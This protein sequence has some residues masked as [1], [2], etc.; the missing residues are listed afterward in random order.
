MV[1]L[2]RILPAA[3]LL[4]SAGLSACS[5]PAG[6]EDVDAQAIAN[7][8]TN[9]SSEVFENN[10]AF[11]SMQSLAVAFPPFAGSA[12]NAATL[13]LGVL[14]RLPQVKG[15]PRFAMR[16]FAGLRVPGEILAI[17]PSNLLGKTFEWDVAT[18]EYVVGNLTGAPANG[19][20]IRLYLVDPNTGFPF[21]PV[22]TIGNVD[23]T[24]ES[25]P[26]G[27]QLGVT[28]RL[29]TVV[30]ADYDIRATQTTLASNL[31]GIGF[32]RSAD[33][34]RQANFDLSL[35][36]R[37]AGTQ[38]LDYTVTGD[39]GTFLVL[40]ADGDQTTADLSF[41]VGRG[42]NSIT[43]EATENA[44]TISG[45][46]LFNGFQVATISGDSG[47]PVFSGA[48]GHELSQGELAAIGEIFGVSLLFLLVLT[49][50]VFGPALV[51]FGL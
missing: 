44:G 43:L 17:F 24:D 3:A 16:P 35:T 20:R 22:Q 31:T 8:L 28:V 50:G 32:F 40:L 25:D 30:V 39:D 14:Q 45:G 2:K 29:F 47:N 42:D 38:G 36:E 5:D 18:D 12:I 49:Y 6:P 27:D 7:G 26:S 11:T 23:L 1:I 51:I 9:L 46:I 10:A 21:E 37:V 34:T 15:T 19:I 33:A 41:E 13:P 4:L 48:N